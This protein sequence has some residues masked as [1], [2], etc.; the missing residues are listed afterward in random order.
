M[1]YNMATQIHLDA[2]RCGTME[3]S[4]AEMAGGTNTT[5]GS[6]KTWSPHST[7]RSNDCPKKYRLPVVLCYLEQMTHSQAANHLNWS[8]GTVRGRVADEREC[9]GVRLAR[10]GLA[11][12][13]ESCVLIIGESESRP[14]CAAAWLN[15]TVAAAM[16]VA[17]GRATAAGA[18]S[19]TVLALCDRMCRP[20]FLT[21]TRS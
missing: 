16:A 14:R 9:C 2:A 6:K 5:T 8:T 19:P 4:A 7:K 21:E 11:F 1:A 13:W 20:M 12:G 3:R 17:A 18:V 15:A 10:R